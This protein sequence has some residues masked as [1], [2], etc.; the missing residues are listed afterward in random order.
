MMSVE[1]SGWALHHPALPPGT[2]FGGWDPGESVPA[3]QAAS[4]VGKKGLLFK[5]PSERLGLSAVHRAL[6]GVP[7]TGRRVK[8]DLAARTGVVASSN[9]GVVNTTAEVAQVVER[10]DLPSISPLDAPN[11][12]ANVLAST[13]AIWFGFG[14][15]NVMVTSGHPA[16]LDA[17]GIAQLLIASD[18]AD[19]VVVVGVEPPG[20]VAR[21]LY[22]H[23]SPLAPPLV[24][25]AACVVLQRPSSCS[26]LR[27][28]PVQTLTVPTSTGSSPRPVLELGQEGPVDLNR[29][30]GSLYGALGV[31]QVAV[32]AGALTQR[33]G[34]RSA[35]AQCGSPHDGWRR[36]KLTYEETP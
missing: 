1:V 10:G 28:H 35:T 4:L 30:A 36:A 23:E 17:I 27:V 8:P 20:D 22:S 12:A 26:G 6:G 18:R 15:P 24:G 29:A 2:R 32:A 25:A 11:V 7:V 19:R 13:V 9:L 5:R 31:A 3:E 21:E 33:P 14:G 16:G 34:L